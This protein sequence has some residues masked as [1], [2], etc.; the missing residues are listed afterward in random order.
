[1][2]VI[3]VIRTSICWDWLNQTHAYCYT[4][5]INKLVYMKL[6]VMAIQDNLYNNCQ[7]HTQGGFGGFERTPHCTKSVH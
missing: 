1:M 3:I 5:I 7:A 2:C 4:H 6:I